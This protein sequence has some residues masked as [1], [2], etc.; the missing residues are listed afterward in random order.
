MPACRPVSCRCSP[1]IS[2]GRR[3]A[4]AKAG[5]PSLIAADEAAMRALADTVPVF[6]PEVGVLTLPAWDCLPYDR[7]SPALRVMAERLATLHALQVPREG[8][9]LLVAT[10]NA[11]T[12]RLLT[13]FR[14]RQLTRRL[15][16]GER[17]ERESW[18][19]LLAPT[20]ISA[21]TPSMRR[22]N[23]RCAGRSSTCS[24]RA[25]R[26]DPARFLRRR[27]RDDAALRPR[28]PAHTG[29]AEASRS[30]PR[31]K[32]C[33]TR[34]ASSASARVIARSS[35]ATPPETLFTSR[36]GGPAAGRHGAVAAA[37]SKTNCRPCSIILGEHDVIVREAAPT[38]R[39]KRGASAIDDYFVNRERAMVSEP[40]ATGRWHR[41]RSTSPRR[42]GGRGAGRTPIHLA[43]YFPRAC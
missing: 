30:C 16:E 18:S 9:Q 26:R 17:V 39:S 34:T 15:A 14:I 37:V 20:A 32:P 6:A 19:R 28:R 7:A 33:L 42:N 8:P 36:V 21:P 41:K 10:A 22:A 4:W 25:K 5:A 27:D 29:P 3:M 40:G 31:P 35:A 1:A 24:R 13:P 23:L 2:R 38:A 43:I 12:Q 11:V